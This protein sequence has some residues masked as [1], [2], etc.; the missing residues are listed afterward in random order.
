M[1]RAGLQLWIYKQAWKDRAKQMSFMEEL[2]RALHRYAGSTEG[3]ENMYKLLK[4]RVAVSRRT[5]IPPDQG[6][7]LTDEEF[8]TFIVLVTERVHE[9]I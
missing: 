4:K 1:Q 5:A 6:L 9:K 3:R 2:R 8:K 7:Q